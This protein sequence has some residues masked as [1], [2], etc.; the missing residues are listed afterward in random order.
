MFAGARKDGDGVSEGEGP[1]YLALEPPPDRSG[2]RVGGK[3]EQG[4]WVSLDE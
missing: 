3:E 2:L 1:A 4:T